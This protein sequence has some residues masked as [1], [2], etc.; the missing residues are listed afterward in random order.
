MIGRLMQIPGREIDLFVLGYVD[1]NYPASIQFCS[2]CDRIWGFHT[3]KGRSAG[4]SSTCVLH[5]VN[6]AWR[7]ARTRPD[8]GSP[9]SPA[10]GLSGSIFSRAI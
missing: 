3:K 5:L 4:H 6:W 2:S 10:V 7:A 8:S 1:E 9:A